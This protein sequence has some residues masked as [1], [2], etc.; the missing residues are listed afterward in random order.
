MHHSESHEEQCSLAVIKFAGERL[1]LSWER[2]RL[3]P[4][5]K[6]HNL[7]EPLSLLH[8]RIFLTPV[9]FDGIDVESQKP[10]RL[11]YDMISGGFIKPYLLC[12]SWSTFR[13]RGTYIFI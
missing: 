8:R 11:K 10:K 4:S 7:I 9:T 3:Q 5:A 12:S 6:E 2:G 13:L 1:L